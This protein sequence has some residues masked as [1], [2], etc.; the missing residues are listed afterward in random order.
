MSTEVVFQDDL[1]TVLT[2]D[3]GVALATATTTELHIRDPDG[4]VLERTCTVSGTNLLYTTVAADWAKLGTHR[5]CAYVEFSGTK[6]TGTA[7]EIVVKKKYEDIG[8]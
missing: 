8:K 7:F 2:I 5:L 3:T 4:T 1:G 6:H